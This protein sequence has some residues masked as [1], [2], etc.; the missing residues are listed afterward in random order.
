MKISSLALVLLAASV[1]A[2]LPTPTFIST[3]SS[4]II[5]NIANVANPTSALSVVLPGGA[6]FR[7]PSSATGSTGSTVVSLQ[8]GMEGNW[9]LSEYMK[10]QG[11]KLT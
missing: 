5:N 8:G 7:W 2:F 9:S 4:N 11:I 6:V 3:F 10:T 1:N